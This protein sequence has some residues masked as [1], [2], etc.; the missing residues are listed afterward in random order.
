M[1]NTDKVLICKFIDRIRNKY[2]ILKNIRPL[3]SV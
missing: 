1:Y 3:A 2:T